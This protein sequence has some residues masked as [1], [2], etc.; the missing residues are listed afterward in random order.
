[1]KSLDTN[2]IEQL[3]AAGDDEI[4]ALLGA[5][6][7]S[8]EN[9]LQ[10]LETGRDGAFYQSA[11]AVLGDDIPFHHDG[12]KRAAQAFLKKWA[13]ELRGAICGNEVL[14]QTERTRAS[15]QLDVLVAS[16][17]ASVTVSVPQLAVEPPPPQT[18]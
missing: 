1:M 12:L 5:A 3:L 18:P 4:Y 15:Q 16:I 6:T 11:P 9:P 14:S 17:V 13:K 2:Q 10:L 8:T 7:L